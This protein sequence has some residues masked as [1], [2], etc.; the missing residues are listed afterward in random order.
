MTKYKTGWDKG[1]SC[2]WTDQFPAGSVP[3]IT[4][5]SIGALGLETLLRALRLAGTPLCIEAAEEIERLC[6]VIDE[7]EKEYQDEI[8]REPEGD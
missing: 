3:I 6:G 2:S 4:S 8:H 5:Q 7:L 1:C